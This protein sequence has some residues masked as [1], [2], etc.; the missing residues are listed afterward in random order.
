VDCGPNLACASYNPSPGC[1]TTAFAC[2]SP[3][4][5]CGGDGDCPAGNTCTVQSGQRVCARPTCAIGRPF[6]VGDVERLAGTSRRDDWRAKSVEPRVAHLS[7]DKRARLAEAWTQV[8]LMEHA[9]IAAFARFTLQLL[10][11]GAPA[12]LIERSNAALADETLHAKL[13]FAI[14]SAYAGH[15]IGP[16]PISI[17]G[18]LDACSLRDIVVTTIR[19][20]CIGETVAAIEAA[21][22]LEHATDPAVRAALARIAQDETRHAAL[23]WR[24]VRWAVDRG[25]DD[26]RRVAQR[27]LMRAATEPEAQVADALEADREL[28]EGGIVP[29][30]LR[31]H[32]RA[33]VL[34][35]V[36]R[37]CARAVFDERTDRAPIEPPPQ[38]R[39]VSA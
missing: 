24:F 27:E 3:S 15:Q 19:E 38:S 12:D 4:D 11:V 14:A 28:L 9:S 6:L 25:G 7:S 34:S 36:V 8:A 31:R 30:V 26:L 33:E 5:Q 32:I 29:E 35:R 16:S 22:A 20:G 21:E 37:V 2:Q 1:P 18:A 13:A 39:G 17:A 10:S 23:A